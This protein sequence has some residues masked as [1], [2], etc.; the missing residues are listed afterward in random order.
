[1]QN[2]KKKKRKKR[3]SHACVN[4]APHPD[5]E[6]G[7]T[8]GGGCIGKG[9]MAQR[10]EWRFRERSRHAESAEGVNQLDVVDLVWQSRGS[11]MHAASHAEIRRG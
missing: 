10:T 9:D 7:S 5:Y 6:G 4:G 2:K 3:V 1:M 8:G 11:L